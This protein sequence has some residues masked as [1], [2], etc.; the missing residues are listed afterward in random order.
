MRG[1]LVEVVV[2]AVEVHG[3]QVDAV[4]AVLLPV[5]L[6]LHQQ[7]LLG[8]PVRRVGLLGVAVPEVVLAE[9]HR[10]VLGV[11]ADG[12]HADEPL[13]AGQPAL[14]D[15]LDAHDRVVVEEL[16]GGGHVRADP[17]DDGGEV[18]DD[19]GRVSASACADR[20]A[21]AQVVLGRAR[22]EHL[23]CAALRSRSRTRPP[24]KPDP[25]VTRTRLPAT[26]SMARDDSCRPG[27]PIRGAGSRD[28]FETI[29]PA[30]DA[31]PRAVGPGTR[32]CPSARFHRS[33]R[34]LGVVPRDVGQ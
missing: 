24:R 15:Q 33:A 22:R 8:Q 32:R 2:R 26:L 5:G 21:V 16:A 11:G 23:G 13:D 3:K 7:H 29:P 14:L 25:P 18:D 27:S 30:A 12:A 17:A 20:V 1:P 31:A 19:L 6:Q 34:R 28:G 9:R 10:D 4:E